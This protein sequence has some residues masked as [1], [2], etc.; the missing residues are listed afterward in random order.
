MACGQ[1]A[2]TISVNL[3]VH[4]LVLCCHV[5][6]VL[7]LAGDDLHVLNGICIKTKTEFGNKG[8][9]CHRAM[10][11]FLQGFGSNV[12]CHHKTTPQEKPDESNY[13]FNLKMNRMV[14]I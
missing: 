1:K 7:W 11:L 6:P 10:Y 14:F 3:N 4:P 12:L 13:Y 2:E 9:R 5:A 8:R